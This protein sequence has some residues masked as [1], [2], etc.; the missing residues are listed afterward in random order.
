MQ[1]RGV[2]ATVIGEFNDSGRCQVNF[3]GKKIMDLE[4]DFLHDG[5]PDRHLESIFTQTKYPEPVLSKV[6]DLTETLIEVMGSL[7]MSGFEFVS[8]QYDHEVQG[9]SV[10][11]PIIGRGRVNSDASVIKPLF[12]SEKGIAISQSLYPH[13]SDIDTYDMA[14]AAIDTAVRNLICVGT[15]PDKIALLDNFCW[16]SPNDP[17]RLGELK[18]AVKACFDMSIVYETPFIS[19]KDSMYNDFRGFD[20]TGKTANISIPPTLLISSIGVVEDVKK[21]V[22]LDFKSAGD[23]IYVLGETFDELGASEYFRYLAAKN[24][25][26]AIGN[27]LP[28]VDSKKNLKLYSKV[29]KAISQELVTAAIAPASGGLAAALLKMS[30]GGSLG[31]NV[32]ASKLKGKTSREDLAIFSESQGRFV[33]TVDPIQKSKFEKILEGVKFSLVG[34]VTDDDFVISSSK[35]ILVKTSTDSLKNAYKE[36]FANF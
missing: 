20:E 11:K 30:V 23:L 17:Q 14:A 33:V 3:N 32:D 10:L 27:S 15:N 12:N 1:R 31:I 29:A 26:R 4:L 24:N 18:R 36:R 2:E 34:V 8:G 5:L 28:K 19:G 9:G 6:G 35:K 22:S 7:N 13:Y 21:S 16:C 25:G